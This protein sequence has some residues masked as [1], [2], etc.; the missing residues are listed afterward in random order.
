MI[1]RISVVFLC[2]SI[3]SAFLIEKRQSCTDYEKY[4]NYGEKYSLNSVGDTVCVC[5]D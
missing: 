1:V 3:S 4:N 5:F 2:Q